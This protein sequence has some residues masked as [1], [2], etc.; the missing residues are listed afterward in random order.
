MGRA[1]QTK[2]MGEYNATMGLICMALLRCW[3]AVDLVHFYLVCGHG[4]M[5]DG[6]CRCRRTTEMSY[7]ADNA[8]GAHG[9]DTNDK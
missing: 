4:H 1:V 5:N 2:R 8:G 7:H 3:Q 9:K 6:C